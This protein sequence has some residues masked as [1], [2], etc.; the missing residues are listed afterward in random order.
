MYDFS[1]TCI[2]LYNYAHYTVYIVPKHLKICCCL[3]HN[4]NHKKLDQSYGSVAYDIVTLYNSTQV[5][6]VVDEIFHCKSVKENN[7]D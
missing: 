3:D 7:S 2:I 1:N 5:Y 6:F 4:G